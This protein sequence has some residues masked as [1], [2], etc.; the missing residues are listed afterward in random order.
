MTDTPSDLESHL[1]YWLRLVSNHVSQSFQRRVE[2]RG[3]TVAEWVVLRL[4]LSHGAQSPSEMAERL[5]MTRGAVSKLIE[6]L[7][8]KHLAVRTFSDSDRRRQ[9]IALTPGGIRLVPKLARLADDNE[10]AFFGHLPSDRVERL[11]RDLQALA[12]LHGFRN[13]PLE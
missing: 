2:A 6:R 13:I 1:G 3:V 8:Q 9:S 11:K 7:C 12:A 5:G 10:R 4:L